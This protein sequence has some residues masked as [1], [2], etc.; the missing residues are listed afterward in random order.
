MR[1]RRREKWRNVE[2]NAVNVLPFA[3]GGPVTGDPVRN[4]CADLDV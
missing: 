3:I 1:E 4:G 2:R